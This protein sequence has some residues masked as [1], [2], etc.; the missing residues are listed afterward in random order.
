MAQTSRRV[1][2]IDINQTIKQTDEVISCNAYKLWIWNGINSTL[3]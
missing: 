3:R 1:A 2:H